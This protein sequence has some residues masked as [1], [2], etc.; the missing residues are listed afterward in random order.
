MTKK[1]A[2]VLAVVACLARAGTV[3]R[4]RPAAGSAAPAAAAPASAAG[5]IIMPILAAVKPTDRTN[6]DPDGSLA[7]RQ[8]YCHQRS[9]SESRSLTC[10]IRLANQGRVN[11]AWTLLCGTIMF[12]QAGLR[13]SKRALTQNATP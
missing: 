13:W 3:R 11:F 12:M 2:L 10:S 1:I 9:G 5:P 4:R 6:G 8:R 7:E